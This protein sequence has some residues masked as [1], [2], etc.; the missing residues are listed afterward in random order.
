MVY[1]YLA[2]FLSPKAY[3]TVGQTEQLNI[4]SLNLAWTAPNDPNAGVLTFQGVVVINSSS[5][6]YLGS[7]TLTPTP[8]IPIANPSAAIAGSILVVITVVMIFVAIVVAI[9]AYRIRKSDQ[10]N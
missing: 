10:S 5:W 6:Y 8:I 2:Y 7:Q 3:S 4:T 1:K 9:C